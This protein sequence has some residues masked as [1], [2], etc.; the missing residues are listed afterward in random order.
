MDLSDGVKMDGVAGNTTRYAMDAY[1]ATGM[2]TYKERYTISA[3]YRAD[4]S[5]RY[6]KGHR[7]GH[8]GSVGAAWTFTNEDFITNSNAKDWLK[9]GKL[10]LSWGVLGNQINSLY[11]YTDTYYIE[12]LNDQIVYLEAS[13]GNPDITW[14][15]SNQLYLV[16]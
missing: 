6:A 16:L 7:W 9:D 10:R 11:S 4:G 5:S 14:E 1:F 8:F 2:Y 13:K 3:N 15:R 12:N